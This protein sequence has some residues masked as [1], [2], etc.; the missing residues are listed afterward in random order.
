[1][2]STAC[3]VHPFQMWAADPTVTAKRFSRLQPSMFSSRRKLVK[4][5]AKK[6]VD[7]KLGKGAVWFGGETV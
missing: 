1:M 2:P 3:R 5:T 6:S 7:N 4:I